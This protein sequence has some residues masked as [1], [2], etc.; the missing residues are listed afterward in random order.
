MSGKFAV[1]DSDERRHRAERFVSLLHD[2]GRAVPGVSPSINP[3]VPPVWF[4][5]E[6]FKKG[7]NFAKR[8]L[9]R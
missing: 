2:D 3:D 1:Q 8:Y 6:L 4:D 9:I 7:Q 5:E